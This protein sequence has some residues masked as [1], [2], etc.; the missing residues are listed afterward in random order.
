MQSHPHSQDALLGKYHGHSTLLF[1]SA[2]STSG[3]LPMHRERSLSVRR[4]GSRTGPNGIGQ[5]MD[6]VHQERWP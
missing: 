5:Q 2:L 3:F 1:A 4:R 6:E